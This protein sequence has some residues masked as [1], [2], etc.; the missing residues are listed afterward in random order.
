[1][2]ISDYVTTSLATLGAVLGILNTWNSFERQRTKLLVRP[3]VGWGPSVWGA[4][5][6]PVLTVEVINLSTFPVSVCDIGFN[7][8]DGRR[9]ATLHRPLTCGK[10]L[11]QR[12][13]AREALCAY[14]PLSELDAGLILDAYTRTTCG[15]IVTGD[16]PALMQVRNGTAAI[17]KEIPADGSELTKSM[18]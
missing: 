15:E 14:F 17:L 13:E 9:Y 1:M 5:S 16:S 10:I 12:L 4:S 3:A 18:R 2:N 6:E 8:K 7:R 11:P